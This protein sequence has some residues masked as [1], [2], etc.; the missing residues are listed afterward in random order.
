MERPGRVEEL[1]PHGRQF[2]GSIKEKTMKNPLKI[3][4]CALA[5]AS[6]G[7]NAT[8]P[9]PNRWYDPS[10]LAGLT[11][12]WRITVTTYN[13]STNVPNPAFQ[14]YITFNIDGTMTETTSAP[15]FQP[16]QRTSGHG[17]WQRTGR[18]FY[19]AVSE[20]FVLFDSIPP[21]GPPMKRGHQRID[22]GIEFQDRNH[23]TSD[24]ATTFFDSTGAVAL[25]LCASAAA[26][27]MD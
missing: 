25:S 18:N 8:T 17:F 23:W 19:R 15:L 6:V 1:A 12:T 22:Q 21:V 3:L 20:A 2:R 11:G 7:A 9:A 16:G 26:E 14:A 4:A 5:L 13:C 10:P 27:R 24:A